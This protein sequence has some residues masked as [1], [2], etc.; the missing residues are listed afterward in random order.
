M[1]FKQFRKKGCFWLYQYNYSKKKTLQS[2]PIAMVD[3][4]KRHF[5]NGDLVEF[6]GA[7]S[8]DTQIHIQPS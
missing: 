3:F 1:T 2:E 7:R 8:V 5:G 6:N 4:A